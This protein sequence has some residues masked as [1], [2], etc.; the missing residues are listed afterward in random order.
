LLIIWTR[1]TNRWKTNLKKTLNHLN[2]I[3][4]KKYGY[5]E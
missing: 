1:L 3:W 5:T 4:S 2:I